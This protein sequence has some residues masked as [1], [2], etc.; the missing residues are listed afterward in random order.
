VSA[1]IAGGITGAV[2]LALVFLGIVIHQVAEESPQFAIIAGKILIII[3]FFVP[4]YWVSFSPP[5]GSA[6]VNGAIMKAS[7]F[8]E[9][10][11][12]NLL[13]DGGKLL[14]GV[15]S[16]G[17]LLAVVGLTDLGAA[18]R[19][20]HADTSPQTSQRFG[21]QAIPTLLVLR[22]GQVAARQTGAVSLAALRS[23]VDSAL[24]AAG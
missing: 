11:L 2:I 4:W 22:H 6:I 5:H 23:W 14:L 15:M 16:A 8:T 19:F 3:G 17:A 10:G 7:T 20:L 1:F 12:A 18:A 24:A 21:V 13:T 9:S